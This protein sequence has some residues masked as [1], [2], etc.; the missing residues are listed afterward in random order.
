M[1]QSG[2]WLH[3]K[4]RGLTK[5]QEVERETLIRASSAQLPL[6]DSPNQHKAD[7]ATIYCPRSVAGQQFCSLDNRQAFRPPPANTRNASPIRLVGSVLPFLSS[8]TATSS[9]FGHCEMMC[10]TAT[11]TEQVPL[12]AAFWRLALIVLLRHRTRFT[13]S[14]KADHSSP[15]TNCQAEW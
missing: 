7:L 9:P 11:G 8:H 10:S 5:R 6:E 12:A 13:I 14:L 2:R 15:L 4:G 1:R 3:K